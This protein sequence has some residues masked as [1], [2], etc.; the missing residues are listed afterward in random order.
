LITELCEVGELAKF[1]KKVGPIPEPQSRTIMRQI[2]DAI[3][4]LHKHGKTKTKFD[5]KAEQASISSI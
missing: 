4:Y 3:S 5:L 2:V 1:I